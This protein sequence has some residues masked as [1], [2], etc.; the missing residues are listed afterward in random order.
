MIQEGT[1]RSY[2][3]YILFTMAAAAL[4][5]TLQLNPTKTEI[6]WFGSAT[7]LRN[8]PSCVTPL[9]VGAD[10]V[11]PASAV[12]DLGVQLDGNCMGHASTCFQNDTNVFFHLRRLRQ[13]RRLL[14]SDVT[15][16]LVAA[17]VLSRLDNGNALLAG[18]PYTLP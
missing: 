4:P 6:M 15:A 2:N 18:L 8:L 7:A 3:S 9:N 1:K 12:R 10:V 16:N 5:A 17:L 14:G 11:Q 13:I